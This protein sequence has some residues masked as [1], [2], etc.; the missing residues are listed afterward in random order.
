[1][2]CVGICRADNRT[3]VAKQRLKRSLHAGDGG[4]NACLE[5]CCIASGV[6]ANQAQKAI[7]KVLREVDQNV[8]DQSGA[9]PVSTLQCRIKTGGNCGAV[10]I[11]KLNASQIA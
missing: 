7:L 9:L 3:V 10:L 6:D 2:P 5:C 8:V 11:D 4:C 1:M